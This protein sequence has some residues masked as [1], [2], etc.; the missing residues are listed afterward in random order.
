MAIVF[1]IIVAAWLPPLTAKAS[2]PNEAWE[3]I[4]DWL[5]QEEGRPHSY[6]SYRDETLALTKSELYG[7][8]RVKP[9]YLGEGR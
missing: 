5:E 3:A 4:L 1:F 2:V 7:S 9:D 8:Q 6:R